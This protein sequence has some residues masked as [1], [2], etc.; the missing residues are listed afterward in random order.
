MSSTR[1]A[2]S[3]RRPRRRVARRQSGWPDEKAAALIAKFGIDRAR[4][5]DAGTNGNQM[6]CSP[7]CFYDA[8]HRPATLM[9]PVAEALGCEAVFNPA[10]ADPD[11]EWTR[12]D[13]HRLPVR[14]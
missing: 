9:Y 13:G 14:H 5:I 11:F 4:A 12:P 10:E 3:S 2:G 1:S 6:A 7:Y 8:T